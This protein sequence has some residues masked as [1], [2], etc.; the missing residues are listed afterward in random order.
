VTVVT[1][2]RSLTDAVEP[3]IADYFH[4]FNAGDF[5]AV[6]SLFA[7]D[8]WLQPPFEEPMTGPA[9]IAR[10]LQ[11][12]ATGIQC[13]PHSARRASGQIRVLGRVHAPGFSLNVAWQFAFSR[14]GKLASTQIELL[15][16]L[17]ELFSL[18]HG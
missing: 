8:G 4:Y 5:A 10:Y 2:T 12:E 6:A 7:A 1:A 3:A 17:E 15:A 14:D 18:S 9:A 11:R 13:Q 16:S